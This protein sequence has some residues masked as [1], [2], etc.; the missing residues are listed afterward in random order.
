MIAIEM[1]EWRYVIKMTNV[2]YE[3]SLVGNEMETNVCSQYRN[4]CAY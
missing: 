3:I 1:L 4:M 2:S